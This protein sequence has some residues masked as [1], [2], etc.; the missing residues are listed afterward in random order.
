MLGPVATASALWALRSPAM[1]QHIPPFLFRLVAKST[2][3]VALKWLLALG[4]IRNGSSF[5]S[6]LAINNYRFSDK[7]RWNWS[8]ET[9]VVTGG[10]SGIGEEITKALAARGVKVFVLDMA[11]LPA[12]LEKGEST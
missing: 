4:L 12:R 6:N 1:Q 9:A 5:L 11:P 8:E 2:L 7:K 10:C 3:V